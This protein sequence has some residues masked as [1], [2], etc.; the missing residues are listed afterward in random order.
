[1]V[2]SNSG[3][4]RREPLCR[5]SRRTCGTLGMLLSF[6]VQLL[7]SHHLARQRMKLVKLRCNRKH[8]KSSKT[9][10]QSRGSKFKKNNLTLEAIVLQKSKKLETLEEGP[11]LISI[12]NITSPFIYGWGTSPADCFA[13][14]KVEQQ[15]ETVEGEKKPENQNEMK[16]CGRSSWCITIYF[17]CTFWGLSHVVSNSGAFTGSPFGSCLSVSTFSS[18]VSPTYRTPLRNSQ[19]CKLCN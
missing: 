19:I 4:T 12:S 3:T 14:S 10:E 6:D 7:Y 13:L 18:L 5:H 11:G 17:S 1:M 8:Y 2:F 15:R 16:A 9:T